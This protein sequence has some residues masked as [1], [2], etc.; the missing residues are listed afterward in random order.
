[1]IE[2][3]CV[4][5]I[6]GS[7]AAS[8]LPQ[9][10]DFR[11]EAK[12]AAAGH[13]LAIMR[14]AYKNQVLNVR[15][16]YT[17]GGGD[18]FSS[19]YALHTGFAANDITVGSPA[20][21]TTAQ[22]INPVERKFMAAYPVNPFNGSSVVHAFSTFSGGTGPGSVPGCSNLVPSSAI[23]WLVPASDPDTTGKLL[24]I[25]NDSIGCSL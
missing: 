23:G 6:V 21:C 19:Y 18:M 8:A 5:V 13:A 14:Q 25:A 9:F 15:L 3:L 24:I 1:M 2:L 22:V 12:V 16:R 7:L 10:L 17:P 4:I 20:A 11:H